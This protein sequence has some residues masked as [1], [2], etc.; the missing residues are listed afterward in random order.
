MNKTTISTSAT[1]DVTIEQVQG[2][3]QVRG[4]EHSEVLV[5]ANPENLTLDEQD[6]VGH[7]SSRGAC[8]LSV[9]HGT[10]SQIKKVGGN[11]SLKLLE[12]SLAID[13]VKGSLNLREIA[14]TEINTISGDLSAQG[15]SGSLHVNQV[16]GNA[17]V[18]EVQGECALDEVSGNLVLR[19]VDGNIKA[20]AKGNAR[21]RL[22]VLAGDDYHIHAGGNLHGRIPEDASARISL[23]SGA[24]SIK[25]KLPDERKSYQEE[26][27]E[28]ILGDGDIQMDFSCDGNLFLA[29][30]EG[31]WTKA[32]EGEFDYGEGTGVLPDDF[33]LRNSNR[34]SDGSS[35]PA[36]GRKHGEPVTKDRGC[37][38]DPGA[39]RKDHASGT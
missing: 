23:V 13:Q 35:D 20:A 22:T 2:E 6:D 34:S 12:G 5:K 26:Q 14:R 28:L 11:A 8:K 24:K 32:G 16:N 36:V 39:N 25:V 21:V 1:P 31:G 15:I 38:H 27:R 19:Q 17:A 30:C 10:K 37:R 4:W 9:P 3:L 18:R 33:S 7:L 29:S